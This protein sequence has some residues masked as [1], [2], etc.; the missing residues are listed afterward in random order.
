MT[1]K[2][3]V[4]FGSTLKGLVELKTG[5]STAGRTLDLLGSQ[6][7][8][9]ADKL[10]KATDGVAKKFESMS[11]KIGSDNA[12]LANAYKTLEFASQG[13]Y[14][15]VNSANLTATLRMKELLNKTSELRVTMS[16]TD[17]LN[18]TADSLRRMEGAAHATAIKTA[19]LTASTARLNTEEVKAYSVA[20]TVYDSQAYVAN[21]YLNTSL[22]LTKST[23]NLQQATTAQGKE[24]ANNKVLLSILNEL[25]TARVRAEGVVQKQAQAEAMLNDGTTVAIAK[26]KIRLDTLLKLETA[27]AR[28]AAELQVVQKQLELVTN[29]TAAQIIQTKR[30][31]AAV[32]EATSADERQTAFN[33]KQAL[34]IEEYTRKIQFLA[35]AKGKELTQL[36]QQYAEQ[37][38]QI[39]LQNTIT[40]NLTKEAERTAYLNS[41]KGRATEIAK[42]YNKAL[43]ESVTAEARLTVQSNKLAEQLKL[44]TGEQF[45]ANSI[46]E[47]K[48]QVE[49]AAA[50]AESKA[51]LLAAKRKETLAELGRTRDYLNTKDG[52]AAE[53]LK[54]EIAESKK[55]ITAAAEFEAAYK[56]QA[57]A[58]V[59]LSSQKH[60]DFAANEVLLA[61][62]RNLAQAEAKQIVQQNQLRKE[63]QLTNNARAREME[64]DRALIEQAKAKNRVV[65]D[66]IRFKTKQRAEIAA[67]TRQIAALSSE[68]GKQL[69]MLR[70][71]LAEEKK[72]L[73]QSTAAYI[74]RN[75]HVKIGAQLTATMRATLQGMKTSIGMYTSSTIL[76]A[77]AAYALSRAIRS[78]VE[79]GVE[80]QAAMARTEAIMGSSMP[81]QHRAASFAAMGEQIRA[82][83]KST[84]FT[85][86]EVAKA[87]T[88]L[89]QAGLSSGQA[90]TALA[91]TLDLA[92]IGQLD[93]A[94]SADHVTNIMMIFRKE[95]ADL[96]GI[97]DVMAKAVT[98]S[99]TN[100]DQLANAL[101]Y[102]GPAADTLG[103]SL[104]T[105]VASI[106][107]LANAGFKASR[108][109]TALRRLFVSL[110]APTKKAQEV[111]DT[112]NI[113]VSDVYGN[114]KDL[115]SIIRQLSV[116][117]ADLSDA[118]KLAAIKNLV[119]V[120]ASSPIAALV[121]QVEG[122]ERMDM[123]LRRAGGS[124]KEMREK[125][126]DALKFDF[127]T[128]LSAYQEVQLSVFD[129][130]GDRL[131]GLTLDL[132]SW[133]GEL[134]KPISD[135]SVITH[136]DILLDRITTLGKLG[137]TVGAVLAGNKLLGGLITGAVASGKAVYALGTSVYRTTLGIKAFGIETAFSGRAVLGATGS[138]VGAEVAI[139]KL[140]ATALASI[141]SVKGLTAALSFIST[142]SLVIYGIYTAFD[143]I[144]TD[145]NKERINSN[146]EAV[147]AYAQSYRDVKIAIQA[148]AEADFKKSALKQMMVMQM[149]LADVNTEAERWRAY[150][151]KAEKLGLDTTLARE[152]LTLLEHQAKD[153]GKTIEDTRK[154]TVT[155]VAPEQVGNL[156]SLTSELTEVV[157]LEAEINR[158][159]DASGQRGTAEM[160]N[161]A[162]TQEKIAELERQKAAAIEAANARSQGQTDQQKN[163]ND[164]LFDSGRLIQENAE[165]YSL[166]AEAA[167][168]TD[169]EKYAD[170]E[171][172][173][174]A[175]EKE[176]DRLDEV[177]RS[178]KATQEQEQRY[179]KLIE[180]IKNADQAIY[181]AKGKIEDYNKS[182]ADLMTKISLV[183]ETEED[184]Y[185][186]LNQE[187]KEV[188]ELRAMEAVLATSLNNA[189]AV[190]NQVKLVESLKKELQLTTEIFAIDESRRKKDEQ[191]AGKGPGDKEKAAAKQL[192]EAQTAYEA[193]RAK[194][195]QVGVSA[196]K[197]A[198]ITEQLTYLKANDVKFTEEQYLKALRQ[199]KIDHYA[200]V[201]AQDKQLQTL[202]K[203]REAYMASGIQKQVDDLAA[204]EKAY[205]GVTDKGAEYTRIRES[206]LKS[207]RPAEGP[208]VQ[209]PEATG[210]FSEFL[211]ASVT[212]S[213]DLKTYDK[214]AVD[215]IGNHEKGNFQQQD[216]FAEAAKAQMKAYEDQQMSEAEHLAAMKK[217]GDEYT[218]GQLAN[219]ALYNDGIATL[220]DQRRVYE[221]QSN[222]LV[223]ASMAGS[224]GEMLG[225]IASAS[226]DATGIQKLAFVAQK[227]LAVAQIIMQSHVAAAMVGAQTGIAGI[228]LGP[229]I[230]AQGYASAGLVAAMAIG[231]LG[232][233]G[234]SGA[235]GSYAGAYDKG[236]YIPTGKHGIVGE[237][238]PEIVNGPAH[239]TG[240]EATARKLG[241]NSGPQAVTI[242]PQINIEYSSEGG[243]GGDSRGDAVMLANTVKLVVIDTIKNE[244]RPNG[245]LYRK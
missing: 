191:G 37:Q 104:E 17:A 183:G 158:L 22:A 124:A 204:L 127:R 239:V 151:A 179:E 44:V 237:Y 194:Y 118:D 184:R 34:A 214:S 212:R 57:Q 207:A 160:K 166:L 244:M 87:V 122:L 225:M 135:T 80:F 75:K 110:S 30:K 50:T 136:L 106:A 195:D 39:S 94:R 150:I 234:S 100:V 155:V 45:K 231:E 192:K 82:M 125:I 228:G 213:N 227:A 102:A 51:I 56:R 154:S 14:N 71:K 216:K 199:A 3:E 187:L 236:G 134:T 18:R 65:A 93:M 23:S 164:L 140:G 159:K 238:G 5:I 11:S 40:T 113:S 132:A 161:F 92:I 232:S 210:P 19:E 68:E 162:A 230:L 69:V 171:T 53:L 47:A 52:R 139:R 7:V 70:S 190:L 203:L 196:E 13:F 241:G 208:T 38:R 138:Y 78:T 27:E 91:P 177:L 73:T 142:A 152:E 81:A 137:L 126:E 206:I 119:G 111:M 181:E 15:S 58:L 131:Q 95:A 105:T 64:V 59:N 31:I 108:A 120:Y 55:A 240:R 224:M 121:K 128:A 189:E 174:D 169:V 67:V 209:M 233:G 116:G 20:K 72:A 178:G 168:K 79:A 133:M 129:K 99:N 76:A 117:M 8:K 33:T 98:N 182:A 176:F 112:F 24:V 26:N 221:E 223:L 89:G 180:L 185:K 61:G 97:V 41:E 198:K 21:A 123:I 66:D 242:S 103:L 200:V 188:V 88:E 6:T 201:V 165:K 173:L 148:A 144:F 35:S 77:S 9:V 205:E 235:S 217:L 4:D 175:L 193:L 222:M 245:M 90:M 147:K 96:T 2:F 28:Q 202:N 115:T 101:T 218:R 32:N 141:T 146:T 60:K 10:A 46:L 143:L 84:Q 48:I 114:T 29:A 109:G 243:S 25:S 157:R 215:L 83:G 62:A 167:A 85:A 1:A 36:Q 219:T 74:A 149:A 43:Q 220:A 49:T 197:L 63:L 229:M 145:N 211:G 172:N 153:L 226:E 42:V 86:T 54:V 16:Q 163:L 186:R 12:Q 156:K 130:V 170:L 107:T